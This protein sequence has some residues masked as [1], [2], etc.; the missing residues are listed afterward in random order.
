M[1]P[2]QREAHRLRALEGLAQAAAYMTHPTTDNL[3]AA[4]LLTSSSLMHITRLGG[5]TV[6][7]RA[8]EA[9]DKLR[10]EGVLAP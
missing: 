9:I 4:I 8:F 1:T 2:T 7:E 3:A 5:D 10:A 6:V